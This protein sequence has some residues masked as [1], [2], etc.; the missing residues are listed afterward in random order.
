[1]GD[2]WPLHPTVGALAA[3]RGR[4]AVMSQPDP[5][6]AAEW[7]GLDSLLPAGTRVRQ[8]EPLFPR[9]DP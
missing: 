5:G 4:K 7:P 2:G 9:I 8:P 6:S 3:G 1:M